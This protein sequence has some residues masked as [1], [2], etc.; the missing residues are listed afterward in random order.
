VEGL[1]DLLTQAQLFA[2]VASKQ[3]IDLLARY[4][5]YVAQVLVAHALGCV[6]THEVKRVAIDLAEKPHLIRMLELPQDKGLAFEGARVLCRTPLV[7]G[8]RCVHGE[9][10]ATLETLS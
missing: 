1:G 5:F 10:I 6:D 4:I 7:D 2:G 8:S 9:R 3:P